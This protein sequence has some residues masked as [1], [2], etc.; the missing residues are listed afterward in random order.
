MTFSVTVSEVNNA[1]T[2]AAVADRT[3][4]EGSALSFTIAA[5]DQ[6]LPA[7]TLTYSLVSAPSGASINAAS[8]LFSWTPTEAQGPSTNQITVRVADNGAPSL[9]TVTN[10]TVIVNEVNLPPTLAAIVNQS[11]NENS[12]L[13]FAV[14]ASDP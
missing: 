8:G 6:D 14:S 7:N 11:I 13:S 1:P 3:V 2:F 9:N 4:N 12:A 10:F 5:S